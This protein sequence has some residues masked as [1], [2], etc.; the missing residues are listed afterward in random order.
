MSTR[1]QVLLKVLHTQLISWLPQL[2]AVNRQMK[3]NQNKKKKSMQL[4]G[5]KGFFLVQCLK[6]TCLPGTF[7]GS[8]T[9]KLQGQLSKS[10]SSSSTKLLSFP[11][12][13]CH[14]SKHVPS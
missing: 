8:A 11:N 3:K 2:L 9:P 5:N 14:A 10:I 1:S 13:L 6:R 12:L 4:P 7:I